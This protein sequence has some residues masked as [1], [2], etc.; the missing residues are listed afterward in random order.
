MLRFPGGGLRPLPSVKLLKYPP[1]ATAK[2]RLAPRV[3]PARTA[4]IFAKGFIGQVD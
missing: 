3:Q 1:M 2:P 4:D